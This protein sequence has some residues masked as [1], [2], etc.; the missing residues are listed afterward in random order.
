MGMGL[1]CNPCCG[2]VTVSSQASSSSDEL[3]CPACIAVS[4]KWRVTVSSLSFPT[5]PAN[6]NMVT[7]CSTPYILDEFVLSPALNPNTNEIIPCTWNSAEKPHIVKQVGFGVTC[8][9]PNE[10]VL[11]QRIRLQLTG[12]VASL[13]S[14]AILTVYWYYQTSSSMQL[15]ATVFDGY[16]G[17]VDGR[18]IN[19]LTGGELAREGLDPFSNTFKKYTVLLEPEV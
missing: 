11:T 3:V 14:A 7:P 16:R 4:R 18:F 17:Q 19:C 8:L 5:N 2:A 9:P 12:T 6:G 15:I 13:T 1:G 10:A